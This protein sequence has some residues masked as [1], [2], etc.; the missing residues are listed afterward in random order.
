MIIPDVNVIVGALQPDAEAH[1]RY[2]GWLT[3]AL[4]SQEPVGLSELALSGAVRILTHPGIFRRPLSAG[5]V[6][7]ALEDLRPH[8]VAVRPGRR[9]W[10]IFT[11]LCRELSATGNLVPDAYHAALTIEHDAALATSDKDFRRMPGLRVIDPLS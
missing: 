4:A 10:G 9:H 1:D 5:D 3:S 2:R 6:L 11:R 8:T 7:D